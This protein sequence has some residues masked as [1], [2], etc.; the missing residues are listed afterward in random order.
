MISPSFLVA[1][2]LIIP[3]QSVD[4]PISVA[5]STGHRTG[6]PVFPDFSILDATGGCWRP[7]RMMPEASI[8]LKAPLSGPGCE[9]VR[10][11]LLSTCEPKNRFFARNPLKTKPEMIV[12]MKFRLAAPGV[13]PENPSIAMI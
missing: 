11:G 8:W 5:N 12:L 9:G 3:E 13:I 10:I 7:P 1:G 4:Y 6:Q 2:N